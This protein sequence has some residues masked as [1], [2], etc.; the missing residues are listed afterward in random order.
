MRNI[1]KTFISCIVLAVG[2]TSCYDEMDSKS[3]IDAQYDQASNITASLGESTV[4]SFSE[5]SINGSISST[6]GVLEA[7]FIVSTSA[8]F[9]SYN[10]YKAGEVA[11]SF[12][13]VINNL[14][15]STTYYVR[16]Y[17]YTISGTMVS[18]AISITTPAA[19]IF[20]LNGVYTAVDYNTEDDSAGESYEVTIE[21]TSGSTTDIKI[22]NLW[23]G[24]KTIEAKYDSATGKISIPAK[25]VIYV[26]ADYGD[27]WMEDVNGSQN[28]SGLFT[29]KGGFL[30]INAFSAICGAGTFGDQYVKMSHK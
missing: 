7:G 8:D 9:A 14:T 15:E 22:T 30:N 4:L 26:H 1:F 12:N 11:S 18:E 13:S 3:S 27:V 20:E 25:Q 10:S 21:F 2:V 28:I 23:G 17:A 29:P 16:S 24:G 19:P 6:E 5:I